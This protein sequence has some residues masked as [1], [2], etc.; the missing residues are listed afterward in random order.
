M[1]PRGGPPLFLAAPFSASLA[2]APPAPPFHRV[3]NYF[4]LNIAHFSLQSPFLLDHHFRDDTIYCLSYLPMLLFAGVSCPTFSSPPFYS[5]LRFLR[6]DPIT[7]KS[8]CFF[9]S[10]LP[11]LLSAS[12]CQPPVQLAFLPPSPCRVVLL[13]S[14]LALALAPSCPSR[15]P[16]GISHRTALRRLFARLVGLLPLTFRTSFIAAI[17]SLA[18]HHFS[19]F[20]CSVLRSLPCLASRCLLRGV[21]LPTLPLLYASC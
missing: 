19:R 10:L 12:C 1:A 20:F 3:Y 9:F 6:Y 14:G 4:F 15:L 5:L 18:D 11:T 8:I 17:Y 16:A 2:R 21:V 7:R 13:C